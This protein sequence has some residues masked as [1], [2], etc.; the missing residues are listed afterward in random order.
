VTEQGL[1]LVNVDVS[2]KSFAQQEREQKESAKNQTGADLDDDDL[3]PV[4]L[5]Q[6]ISTRLVDH[7]A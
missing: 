5:S 3:V 2:D 4:G 1:N 7:Y 6:T